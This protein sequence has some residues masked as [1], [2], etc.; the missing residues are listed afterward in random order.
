MEFSMPVYWSGE[1]F[2][3]TADLPNPGIK[4][5]PPALQKDLLPAEP[6]EKTWSGQSIST[7]LSG[8]P[9]HLLIPWLQSPSTVILESKKVKSDTV[10]TFYPSI[11]HEVMEPDAKIFVF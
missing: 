3:S 8:K 1:P 6:Q 7:E 5:G 2:L 11:C 10:S 9:K 4:P